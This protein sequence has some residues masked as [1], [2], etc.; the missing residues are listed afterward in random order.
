MLKAE[1]QITNGIAFR[2]ALAALLAILISHA[3]GW[4]EPFDL[5]FFAP[6]SVYINVLMFPH[7]SSKHWIMVERLVG[8]FFGYILAMVAVVIFPQDSVWN[9]TYGVV[10][11]FICTYLIGC[12]H[13][14][15]YGLFLCFIIL[16]IVIAFHYFTPS[17]VK[18]SWH[19]PGSVLIALISLYVVDF[20][21]PKNM[22]KKALLSDGGI[23]F[24]ELL[25]HLKNDDLSELPI[26]KYQSFTAVMQRFAERVP[27]LDA[28]ELNLIFPQLEYIVHSLNL[29]N[30]QLE[31]FP[32]IY[33]SLDS[34]IKNLKQEIYYIIVK[35]ENRHN[36]SSLSMETALNSLKT[37]SQQVL[38]NDELI[39]SHRLEYEFRKIIFI[40]EDISLSK[41]ADSNDNRFNKISTPRIKYKI[42]LSALQFAIRTSLAITITALLLV[43]FRIPGLYQVWIACLVVIITPNVNEL[44]YKG[45]MRLSGVVSGGV[46]GIIVA[47]IAFYLH[48]LILLF[49][50]FF[51][52]L[53]FVARW[54]LRHRQYE[55]VAIQCGLIFIM[56]LFA[57]EVGHMD[58]S[59]GYDRFI[60]FFSGVFIALA[61]SLAMNPRLPSTLIQNIIRLLFNGIEADRKSVV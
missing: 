49:I 52:V 5:A 60:G 61:V 24:S 58:F 22:E 20:L 2:I 38:Q 50:L 56:M 47:V 43:W 46:I 8:V 4:T 28:A 14:Y 3:I 51:F 15:H 34:E 45:L 36:Y 9:L 57:G 33:H 44:L 35:L 16:D 19:F 21:F 18:T 59:L 11:T 12:H 40:L 25:I 37:K 39:Q 13:R 29:I 17:L 48:S 54:G 42:D 23:L 41:E 31:D 10:F 27:R 30:K 32:H 55:Y 1:K 53:F 26:K 7:Q 6:F